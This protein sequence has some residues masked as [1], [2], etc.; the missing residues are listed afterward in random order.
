MIQ[1]WSRESAETPMTLPGIQQYGKGFGHIGFLL[2]G[3][4]HVKRVLLRE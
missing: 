4:M 1:M 3:Q 2:R